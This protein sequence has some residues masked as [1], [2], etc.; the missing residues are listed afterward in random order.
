MPNG[1]DVFTLVGR[2]PLPTDVYRKIKYQ[3]LHL[4]HAIIQ[5]VKFMPEWPTLQEKLIKN[6]GTMG[7]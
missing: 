1:W 6:S 2:C 3:R 4:S 7:K 5:N